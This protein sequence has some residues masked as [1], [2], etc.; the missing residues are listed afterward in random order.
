[1]P[2]GVSPTLC[3]W[4][5]RGSGSKTLIASMTKL[6]L[7]ARLVEVPREHTKMSRR[8]SAKLQRNCLYRRE[9]VGR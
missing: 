6:L 1:M 5:T 2:N 8:L 3:L 7:C 9:P 4:N